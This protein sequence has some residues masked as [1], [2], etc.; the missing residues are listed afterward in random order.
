MKEEYLTFIS[1]ATIHNLRLGPTYQE[2]LIHSHS[3]NQVVKKKIGKHL[4]YKPVL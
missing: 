3:A 2:D 1:Y 4:F